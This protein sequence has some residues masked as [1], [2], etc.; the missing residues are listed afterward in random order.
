MSSHRRTRPRYRWLL[1]PG[2]VT[3]GVIT[4]GTIT[5]GSIEYGVT[6]SRSAYLDVNGVATS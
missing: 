2:A 1:R 3:D 6:P 4:G 5:P